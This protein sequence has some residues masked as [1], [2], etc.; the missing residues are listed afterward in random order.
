MRNKEG[1]EMKD[2]FQA[3]TNGDHEEFSSSR[4]S[5]LLESKDRD[6]LLS[7]TG[8]QVLSLSLYV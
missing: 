6:Y 1:K 2:G 7:S 5:S 8:A 3:L 4:F